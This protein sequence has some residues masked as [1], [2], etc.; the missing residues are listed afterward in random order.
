MGA[1]NDCELPAV[2]ENGRDDLSEC[3]QNRQIWQ[4]YT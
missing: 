4:Y 3:A 1:I 2:L